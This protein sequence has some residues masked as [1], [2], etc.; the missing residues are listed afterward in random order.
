MKTIVR[1]PL[2]LMLLII[3]ASCNKPEFEPGLGSQESKLD[4]GGTISKPNIILILADDVGYE[5][6]NYTGGQSYSTPN[7]NTLARTGTQFTRCY[8]SPLCSPSRFMLLTGKYNFRNYT[9]WGKLDT[10]QRTIAN[11]LRTAGYS[12]CAVGKWQFNGG[13]PSIRKFGFQKY[14][15][16]NPFY[17]EA[18]DE[19]AISIYKN[20]KVYESGAYWPDSAVAG[21]YGEDLFRNYMFKFIDENKNKTPFFV[22][23]SMNLVHKPFCPTPDDAAFATWDPLK[24]KQPGDS[25]YYPSMVKYMDKL[26]GQLMNKLR[27]DTLQSKTLVLFVGD[28]G[29]VADIHSLYN[30]Q[31]VTGGKSQPNEAGTHVPMVAF[32]Q[33]R[34]MPGGIDTN[35]ISLVDF[36]S[37]ISEVAH[38]PVPATYGTTDGISFAPQFIGDYSNVRPWIFCHFVGSGKNETNPLFLKR[39]MHNATYKQYDTLPNPNYNKRFF[40]TKLDPAERQ[41]IDTA[42]MTLREKTVSKNFLNNMKKLH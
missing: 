25:I 8:S 19:D 26:V 23:W 4:A 20:P 2:I 3:V 38:K 1:L 6:P 31:I 42:D 27:T 22:Y 5:T 12:T 9:T 36:M 18:G 34:I 39:W 15:V 14:L 17:L 16:T 33:G 41:P 7:L 37:T 11:L 28:N 24:K 10:S 35:L 13:G 30:G 29:S 40:N 21:K 32:M